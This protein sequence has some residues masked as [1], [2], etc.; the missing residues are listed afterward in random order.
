MAAAADEAVAEKFGYIGADRTLGCGLVHNA[1]A[2]DCGRHTMSTEWGSG[3][4]GSCVS[5]CPT[6]G[7]H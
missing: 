3:R 6:F 2:A 1:R 4:L 5:V 7:L